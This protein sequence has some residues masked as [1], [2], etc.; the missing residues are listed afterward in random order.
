MSVV[1]SVS[2]AGMIFVGC[3]TAAPDIFATG[4]AEETDFVAEDNTGGGRT[5]SEKQALS[6]M[7]YQPAKETAAVK[8]G[9]KEAVRV[10][11]ES[12]E[13][14]G[15][16]SADGTESVKTSEPVLKVGYT[17]R[18]SVMVGDTEELKP[19]EVQI[20]DREEITLPL[21]GKISCHGVTLDG[22]RSRLTSRY[23]EFMRNPEVTVSFVYDNSI[24]S[25]YGQVFVQG[26]V[27]ASGWIN[28]PPTRVL[29]L[30][31]AIQLAGGFA[32]SARKSKVWVTRKDEEGNARRIV[33]DV[34]AIGKHGDLDKDIVLEP[35]DVI[36]VG[37][38]YF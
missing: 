4:D 17:L 24:A 29:K 34:E 9:E 28:I 35:D 32:P 1:F 37:E 21:V 11:K 22:L 38:S 27:N 6:V 5:V 15:V 18:I 3:R 33:V 36:Y 7:S 2:S 20:S 12:I 13:A 10:P 23:E 25:P 16:S 14:R 8:G 26:R 19:T 31:R 30:S